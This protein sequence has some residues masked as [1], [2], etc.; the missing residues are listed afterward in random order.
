MAQ[1][2]VDPGDERPAI[3]DPKLIYF[4]EE[5]DAKTYQAQ[6]S[7]QAA[8]ACMATRTPGTCPRTESDHQLFVIEQ[9]LLCRARPYT[10]IDPKLIHQPSHRTSYVDTLMRLLGPQLK[11]LLSADF[12]YGE[13]VMAAY[14]AGNWR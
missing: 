5:E 7:S 12:R 8:A 9:N 1:A 11:N 2:F 10:G 6:C 13:G 14:R 3:L 4:L